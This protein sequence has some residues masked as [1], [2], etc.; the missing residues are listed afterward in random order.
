MAGVDDA[1]FLACRQLCPTALTHR[2]DSVVRLLAD[3]FRKAGAAVRIEHRPFDGKR[4]R[5]DLEIVIPEQTLFVDVAI[6]HPASA[7]RNASRPLHYTRIAET[8]KEVKYT[9]LARALG[10]NFRPFCAESFGAV[11]EK[12]AEV[13]KLLRSFISTSIAAP[14]LWSLP[15]FASQAIA[16]AI[17]AGN[18]HAVRTGAFKSRAEG[19]IRQLSASG[20]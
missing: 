13:L 15:S 4:V 16:I 17:Q 20:G 2:H 1:H 7:S 11:G 3:L 6:T 8:Q 10:A 5:P 12:A 18:A 14:S 9:T 19:I